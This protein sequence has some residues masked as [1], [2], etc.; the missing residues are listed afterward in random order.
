M[1]AARRTIAA[2]SALALSPVAWAQPCPASNQVVVRLHANHSIAAVAATFGGTVAGEVPSRD[3]YLLQFGTAGGGP[4]PIA[5]L[6]GDERVAWLEMNFVHVAPGGGTQSFFVAC[7]TTTY[8]NQYALTLIGAPAAQQ[9][10]LG[11]GTTVAVLDTGI[12]P[13]LVPIAMQLVP[14]I[15]VIDNNADTA[16]VGNGLDDDGDELIDELVGH[17]TFVSGVV[18]TVAP[19]AA[20]LP[21]KVLNSDG[22]GASFYTAKGVYHAIDFGADVI[23]LSLYS[24]KYS[25]AVDEAVQ[26]AAAAGILIV[27]S[28]GNTNQQYPIPYPAALPDVIAVAATDPL[29]LK[30]GFSGYGEYVDL[31][32]PGVDIVSVIPAGGHALADGTSFAAA[33]VSA[34]AALIK[35]LLVSPTGLKDV[36]FDTAFDIDPL[37]PQYGTLLGHGRI[38]LAG[39]AAAAAGQGTVCDC[40]VDGALT[41]ADFGCFQTRFMLG[42]SYADCNADGALTVS[43][44]GC[45]Q[46]AFAAGCP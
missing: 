7:S 22:V 18:A 4:P 36:L 45:F 15:N 23:N 21:V 28:V 14:G 26:E 27:A 9:L 32:A 16:D 3:L 25:R 44:F 33:F 40:N 35:P 38:D 5:G 1:M 31:A 20:L 30:A 17:G 10:S 6:L 8:V 2:C 43:D 42:D 41:V 13:E 19:A 12:S 11:T 24:I 29:D 39:A 34:A 46:T 37:N